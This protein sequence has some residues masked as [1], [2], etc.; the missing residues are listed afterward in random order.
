MNR[1]LIALGLALL[2]IGLAWPWLGR[3][4]W[5]RLPG[6]IFVQRDNFSFYFP[7]TTGLIVSIVL[8]VVIWFLRK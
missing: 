1:L 8:S 7:L 6:D 5:G 4:P 3:I 2:A